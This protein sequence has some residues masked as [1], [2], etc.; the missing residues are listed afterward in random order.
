MSLRTDKLAALDLGP[1]W[2]RR[3]VLAS[4]AVAAE[5]E[6]TA[7]ETTAA[8][9]PA[10]TPVPAGQHAPSPVARTAQKLL[11]QVTRSAHPGAQQARDA[12]RSAT[13]EPEQDERSQR[14]AKLDWDALQDDVR[15]CTACGLCSQRQQTVFGTGV[16]QPD[17]LVV[18]E[19]PGAEEDRQ[20]EP[21]VGAAG[22][23]LDNMLRAVN[24][25]RKD[26]VFIANVLKCRPPA[27]RNP[28]VDE[29]LRCS[30]YLDRQLTLLQPKVIFA[31]GR[32]AIQHLLKS[33]APVS[34]LRGKVHEWQ[35][36]PVIVSYHPAYLLRNLPDKSKSWSDLLL[37][38]NTLQEKS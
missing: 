23:L 14:I 10:E 17:V 19:A 7:P 24:L 28:A 25:S 36:I 30:P 8:A 15:Q 4:M 6:I 37:L 32:F 29:V 5:P 26:Q 34:A 22:Q 27:N 11:E 13:I 12:G 21:F 3:A 18:G 20:G 2:V 33:D 9:T 38:Q 16:R 1:F 31:V 35:G